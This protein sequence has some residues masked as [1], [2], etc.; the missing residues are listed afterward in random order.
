MMED[1]GGRPRG[2]S[3]KTGGGR[4][5][6]PR[7][8]GDSVRMPEEEGKL[9][10]RSIHRPAMSGAT[11]PG[12]P[13]TAA[14][15]DAQRPKGP[16]THCPCSANRIRGR[17]LVHFDSKRTRKLSDPHVESRGHRE[18]DDLLGRKEA[19]HRGECHVVHIGRLH[20]FLRISEDGAL[21]FIEDGCPAPAGEAVDLCLSKSTCEADASM[22]GEL[23]LALLELSRAQNHE[24]S[25]D[26]RR[27]S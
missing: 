22:V 18:L 8:R 9:T 24:L 17:G 2:R 23:V 15:R 3:W 19:L 12:Q 7:A 26:P 13:R 20:H 10:I 5:L 16:R 25:V 14:R 11:R 4:T 6:S 27:H 21:P 1:G